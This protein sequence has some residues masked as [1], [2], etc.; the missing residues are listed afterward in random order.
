M[1]RV[2][3]SRTATTYCQYLYCWK[4]W[5]CSEAARPGWQPENYVAWCRRSE[6]GKGVL[7]LRE[8]GDWWGLR[9]N[10]KL[11]RKELEQGRPALGCP[12]REGQVCCEGGITDWNFPTCFPHYISWHFSIISHRNIFSNT[13]IINEV[14]RVFNLMWN[15]NIFCSIADNAKLY[16]QQNGT[17]S[18]RQDTQTCLQVEARHMWDTTVDT[19]LAV[20]PRWI[21]W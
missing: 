11:F 19:C 20:L 17:G 16:Y 2:R 13:W 1:E 15:Y 9:G 4:G 3:C 8:R 12:R 21:L 10:G 5:Q 18:Y 14:F 7:E 6:G